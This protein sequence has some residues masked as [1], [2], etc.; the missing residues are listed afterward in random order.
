MTALN[1]APE[2]TPTPPDVRD[3]GTPRRVT[4]PWALI[5]IA[6]VAFA[7][8]ATTLRT[9]GIS[10]YGLLATASPL[11]VCSMVIT[12]VA[13]G[14]C[15]RSA[16]FRA[17]VAATILMIAVQRLPA[18]VAT[19]SPMYS[20]TYKH[21][22]VVD[23]IQHE[24]AL[25]RGV[26]VY[27]SWPGVF[28]VTAW[29]SD[30]TG[31]EPVTLAHGFTPL[32]HLLF[33]SLVYVA[34]RV[35]DLDK[36]PALTA[37]FLAA[38]LN[39]VAQDYYSPQAFAM[40]LTAGL[41]T[42]IGLSR[43]RPTGVVLIVVIF[44]AVTISHQLT[45]FWLLLAIGLLVVTKRMKPWWIVP[46]LAVIAI[47]FLLFNYDQVDQYSLFSGNI[48]DNAKSNVPTV[49]S[50]GQ[51]TTS[52]AV[53]ILSGTVW[54]STALVL[55]VRWRRKQPFFALGVLALS[56]M[57]ILGGQSY[58]GE[59]IF[60]VFL[61]S[62]LGCS[63][64]LAPVLAG[65][66]RS[67][68]LKFG[69]ASVLLSVATVFSAQGYFGGWFA[70]IMPREQVSASQTVLAQA[71]FPAY[72]TV[73]AP[74]WPQ[75]S[76]WR[77]V[78]YARFND[79]FDD[80]MIFAANLVGSHFDSDRD[81]QKFIET[82]GSRYDASTYLVFTEQMRLYAWYFGILPLDALPNLKKRIHDDPRWVQV[83]DDQGVTIFQ[84]DVERR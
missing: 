30:L 66:L 53:R 46:I 55:L 79:H 24:H 25:A 5:V 22:G 47:G 80:P 70:N 73:A 40:V 51:R 18:L 1:T 59:A 44:T 12:A 72:L 81:Y 3:V 54:V 41:V 63:I 67:S 11:F 61:Y 33:V 37:A 58:G 39:W 17:G 20:W 6:T 69:I 15:V 19:D 10:E 74:V 42:L 75:R 45:P 4:L 28:G 56:P 31:I 48:V 9:A 57:L 26:D 16:D 29:L 50:V 21:L 8:S 13:F 76:T 68:R 14:L 64:V 43:T 7:Y 52:F 32:F 62:L 27:H 71:D 83:Y 34:A 38:T 65:M 49:G 35:W 36:L 2:Q 23:Y 82:I 78:E 60:R 84:H 77:Y